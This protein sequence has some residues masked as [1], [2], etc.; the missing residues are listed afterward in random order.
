MTG[1]PRGHFELVWRDGE[2]REATVVFVRDPRPRALNERF[3]AAAIPRWR[4]RGAVVDID[5]DASYT[6][7]GGLTDA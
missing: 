3:F 1:F 5:V 2:W 6:P 7:W 4:A